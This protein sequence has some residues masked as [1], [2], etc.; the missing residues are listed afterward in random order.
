MP[1]AYGLLVN[2]SH[3]PVWNCWFADMIRREG[4]SLW[5]LALPLYSFP[6]CLLHGLPF[7]NFFFCLLCRRIHSSHA[8][9]NLNGK[10]HMRLIRKRRQMHLVF[11]LFI[12]KHSFISV[13]LEGVVIYVV[14]VNTSYIYSVLT[15]HIFCGSLYSAADSASSQPLSFPILPT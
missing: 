10:I 3:Q 11:S 14:L 4:V 13:G 9:E 12:P 15:F 8:W 5:P 6:A 2:K 1:T 7:A